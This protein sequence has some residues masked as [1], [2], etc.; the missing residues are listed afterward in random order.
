MKIQKNMSQR[1]CLENKIYVKVIFYHRFR[2][3]LTI[4]NTKQKN[5]YK[6]D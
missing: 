2:G 5:I 1:K 4:I 3:I 6:N